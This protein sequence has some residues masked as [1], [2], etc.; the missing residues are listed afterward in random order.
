MWPA[1][2]EL[3]WQGKEFLKGH[4][5]S[6]EL[7]NC[8]PDGW[9]GILGMCEVKAVYDSPSSTFSQSFHCGLGCPE[10]LRYKTL[11]T[12]FTVYLSSEGH[13][14]TPQI[15]CSAILEKSWPFDSEIP[16]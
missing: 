1:R 12:D 16:T 9:I 15:W 7:L 2:I 14:V 3:Y 4:L 10:Y 13:K 5:P 11:W 8:I 6:K